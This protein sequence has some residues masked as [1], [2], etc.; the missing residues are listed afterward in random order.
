MAH[1]PGMAS[2]GQSV[3]EDRGQDDWEHGDPLFRDRTADGEDE[4][5]AL[6]DRPDDR[7]SLYAVLNLEADATPD[8][9]Q[10][11]YRRLA[12]S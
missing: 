8:D 3:L 7:D 4:S 5:E 6:H 12:G 9:I 1:R 10:R 11:A 2:F